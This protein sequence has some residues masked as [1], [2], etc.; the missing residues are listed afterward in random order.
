[1]DRHD[2]RSTRGRM[3]RRDMIGQ[4]V[5]GAS[6]AG[7]LAACARAG[8]PAAGGRPAL[9]KERTV[10]RYQSYKNPEELAVFLQG[11]Q[12]WAERAGNVEVQTDVVP[13]GEYIEKL[14][15]RIAGGDPPDM[16][17]VNDRMSSDFIMRNTL[18][19]LTDRIKRDAREVDLDDIF[20]GF[21][22]VMLY[23]GKR[24][25]IPDYCGPTVM[26]YN[27]LLFQQ[28][29]QPETRCR[30]SSCPPTRSAPASPGRHC[31]GGASAGT[32]SKG[33]ARTTPARRSG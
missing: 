7:V 8:A 30:T 12:R 29:A 4:A 16:M 33:L 19:D 18:L 1:M 20:P 21:R 10:L 22:D 2:D 27:K 15:V 28:A 14:L 13:Q 6:G 23:K 25:G 32:S 3:T 5:L 31:C 9:F 11:V 24:Y 17:E 26:Y